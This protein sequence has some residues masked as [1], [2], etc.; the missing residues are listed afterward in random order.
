[1]YPKV[2]SLAAAWFITGNQRT[3]VKMRRERGNAVSF[4]MGG[5]VCPEPLK[6]WNDSSSYRN[7]RQSVNTNACEDGNRERTRIKS[8]AKTQGRKGKT[9]Y[10]IAA[11][12]HKRHKRKRNT[13]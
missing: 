1:M 10:E 7:N 13:E 9:E 4:F 3:I 2:N 8:H 5:A 6:R 12:K 11:K